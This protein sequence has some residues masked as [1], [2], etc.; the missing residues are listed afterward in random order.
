MHVRGEEGVE[1]AVDKLLRG[2]QVFFL[3]GQVSNALVALD[4]YAAR[5]NLERARVY[6]DL[7]LDTWAKEEEKDLVKGLLEQAGKKDFV[8]DFDK[9][10]PE[11]FSVLVRLKEGAK[12]DAK[13]VSFAKSFLATLEED[14]SEITRDDEGLQFERPLQGDW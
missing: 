9:R 11:V 1:S 7:F 5:R 14:L 4:L 3:R 2:T 8:P 10:M 13:S 12:L 6:L